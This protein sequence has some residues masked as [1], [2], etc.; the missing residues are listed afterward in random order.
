MK[1]INILHISDLHFGIESKKEIQEKLVEKREKIL[2]SLLDLLKNLD[3]YWKSDIIVISG[4]IGFNGVEKEYADS[5]RWIRALLNTLKLNSEKLIICAGN[6]DKYLDDKNANIFPNTAEKADEM[7]KEENLQR[8]CSPFKDFIE[9][10]K[11][12]KIPPLEYKNTKNY[13]IG[14]KEIL[15]LNFLVLNSAWYARGGDDDFGKLDV[16]LPHIIEMKNSSQLIDKDNIISDQITVAVL[17]HPPEYLKPYEID[18]YEDREPAYLHLTKCSDLILS[19]HNHGERIF[20]PDR[21][22]NRSW[23]FKTGATYEGAEYKNNCEIIKIYKSSRIAKRLKIYYRQEEN[24]W[25]TE[26]DNKSPYYFSNGLSRLKNHTKKLLG[27]INDKIG[28]KCKVE[29]NQYYE[30]INSEL[31]NNDV[32]FILGKPMIGKSVILKDMALKLGNNNEIFVF[33]VDNFNHNSLEHYLNEINVFDYFIDLLKAIEYKQQCYIFIDQTERVLENEKRLVVFKDIINTIQKVNEEFSRNWC[34]LILCCRDESFEQIFSEIR[35]ILRNENI[36]ISIFTIEGFTTENIKLVLNEFPKIE[37]LFRRPH[38]INIFKIP[39]ILDILAIEG[40]ELKQDNESKIN[41]D[42]FFTETYLFN[43]FWK[44]IIRNNERNTYGE[45]TPDSRVKL[46]HLIALNY[47]NSAKPFIITSN[48]DN[49]V[50]QSL[51][52]DNIISMEKDCL[53]FNHAV[54]EEYSL[55]DFIRNK[56]NLIED[57]IIPNNSSRRNSR[58]F[59]L[60]SR[61]FLE[62]ENNPD[63]WL[64]I[65]NKLRFNDAISPFWGQDFILG[66]LKSENSLKILLKMKN[67]LLENNCELL[68]QLLKGL[69]LK[70]VKYNIKKNIKGIDLDFSSEPILYEWT[71]IIIFILIIF[72]ELNDEALYE[73]SRIIN[74]WLVKSKLKII[75]FLDQIIKMFNEIIEERI[76]VENP[77]FKLE[78][79]KKLELEK[80]LIHS[81]VWAVALR[82]KSEN[83]TIIDKLNISDNTKW[84]FKDVIFKMYAW[85]PLC[86][87]FPKYA[88]NLLNGLL[89]RKDKNEIAHIIP[90]G[91]D[92]FTLDHAFDNNYDFTPTS[93]EIFLNFNE[94]QGLRLIHSLI[95]KAMEIWRKIDEPVVYGLFFTR[96]SEHRTPMPHIIN[97]DG[98][99]VEVLGDEIVYC[100]YMHLGICPN[101]VKSALNGLKN[102]MINQIEINNRE[103]YD[104]F[105]KIILKT[106]SLSIIAVCIIVILK[107]LY[108][109][110]EENNTNL[111]KKFVKCLLPFINNPVFWDLELKR[112][113]EYALGYQDYHRLNFDSVYP[114]ILFNCDNEILESL[115]SKLIE[116]PNNPPFYFKE[117]KTYNELVS[118]RLTLCNRLAAMTNKENWVLIKD[119]DTRFLSY[120][121]PPELYNED[122]LQK[123]QEFSN[124]IDL[125]NWIW[126]SFKNNK[127]E[128]NYNL[129][130]ILNFIYELIKEDDKIFRPRAYIDKSADRAEIIVGFFAIL[131]IY[132]W[133]FIKSKNLE[134]E[135]KRMILRAVFREEPENYLISPLSINPLGYKRSA[136]RALPFLFKRF[137]TDKKIKNAMIKLSNYKN[138]EV[139][140]FLF[141]YSN[142][143][144]S[145]HP[146][147]IW[148]MVSKLRRIAKERAIINNP[149]FIIINKNRDPRIHRT[150]F[151][152]INK[153]YIMKLY[154]KRTISK[155]LSNIKNTSFEM[156]TPLDID[157][158]FFKSALKVIPRDNSVKNMQTDEKFITFLRQIL[159]FTLYNDIKYKEINEFEERSY[160]NHCKIRFYQEWMEEALEIISNALLHLDDKFVNE[161]LKTILHNWNKTEKFMEILIAQLLISF[162]QPHFEEKFI[163]IWGKIADTVYLSLIKGNQI[164]PDIISLIFFKR[165]YYSS[166]QNQFNN[167]NSIEKISKIINK[168]LN[169]QLFVEII[170]LLNEL[171]NAELSIS[172]IK[173]H[174]VK[175]KNFSFSKGKHNQLKNE[176]SKFLH[177]I[178]EKNKNELIADHNLFKSFKELVDIMVEWGNPLAAKLQEDIKL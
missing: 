22:F 31:H 137:P 172:F 23:L 35:Q 143:L 175:I 56:T 7:L 136:A 11:K 111:I 41:K 147:I 53:Y 166:I 113:I 72:K 163:G 154:I 146:R 114:F 89:I 132:N 139:R 106:N 18:M 29:R 77:N 162:N 83:L 46:L 156:L 17:H 76:L 134:A 158:I 12:I 25:I 64:S 8:I 104:L 108:R 151:V 116:S 94:D 144:W 4:D 66:I 45:I 115:N 54:Y 27:K 103:P 157:V 78:F 79:T 169:Y 138:H 96:I 178:W 167:S 101:I 141:L 152:R 98:N 38:L 155:L 30:K 102:W 88:L 140:D 34:K 105:R 55:L 67:I 165:P 51:I 168:F 2:H 142:C 131:L 126:K 19:G 73:S 97:L 74:R 14:C 59:Q 82:Q 112:S 123:Y 99:K 50:I 5:E 107:N 150:Q 62:I 43:Q 90:R 36:N 125:R 171:N 133:D 145:A 130:Q 61:I 48:L 13:L 122:E 118:D 127:I 109:A 75:E 92:R 148:K 177:C 65:F 58:S 124:L 93:F 15:G 40:F 176:I 174:H 47:F 9:F 85:I 49:K 70:C 170:W 119:S 57:F 28:T 52:S 149:E 71:S 33:N 24:V 160:Y 21:K 68:I 44:Q 69:Q 117:E 42:I 110:I 6:H 60:F 16:G 135:S 153:K 84:I 100:W 129:E 39:K 3:N 161:F 159:F 63:E 10:K 164:K 87:F 128:G 91:Y 95:D 120:K 121:P 26:E 173:N 86:K 37:S 20:S 81:V 32:L 80:K 1:E